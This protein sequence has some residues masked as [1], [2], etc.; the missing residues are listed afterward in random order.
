[1]NLCGALSSAVQIL[2]SFSCVQSTKQLSSIGLGCGII[3]VF[4]ITL[5]LC[6]C[7]WKLEFEP[8]SG[9]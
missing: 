5:D 8:Q 6:H 1:M 3:L 4:D 7:P 9:N 2:F